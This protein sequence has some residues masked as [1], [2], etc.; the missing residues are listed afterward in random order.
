MYL[1]SKAVV[2]VEDHGTKDETVDCSIKDIGP[3][4]HVHVKMSLLKCLKK[5]TFIFGTGNFHANDDVTV[6]D[7]TF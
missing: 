2:V 7:L 4:Q 3:T 6:E 5:W 1:N